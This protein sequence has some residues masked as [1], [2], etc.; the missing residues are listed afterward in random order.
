MSKQGSLLPDGR[1]LMTKSEYARHRGITPSAVTRAIAE[2]RISTT[3][4]EGRE[5]IDRDAADRQW[6]AST[7][8]RADVTPP[9]RPRPKSAVDDEDRDRLRAARI[10]FEE[11]RAE[12]ANLDLDKAAG[13]LVERAEVDFVLADLGS[14]IIQEFEQL[15]DRLAPELAAA[16]GDREK[17][18]R[19]L[20]DGIGEALNRLAD[21]L[22]RRAQ[23][24]EPAS[25]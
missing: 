25:E 13:S 19:L 16:Q 24:L 17:V 8:P 10:K 3:K 5:R 2:G 12:A 20:A 11:A 22:A 4:I 15:P 23:D 1:V 9:S 21:H 6:L 18:R 7:R 14:A